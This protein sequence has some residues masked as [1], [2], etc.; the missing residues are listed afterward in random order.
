VWRQNRLRFT[1]AHELGHWE[2]HREYAARLTFASFEDFARHFKA[3][4]PSRYW[5]EKEANEFAGQLLVPVERLREHFDRFAAQ[6]GSIMP[7]WL[8]SEGIGIAR[9]GVGAIVP[10]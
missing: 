6:I 1:V 3:D 9:R 7:N 5:L 10:P 2:L 4:D 8:R